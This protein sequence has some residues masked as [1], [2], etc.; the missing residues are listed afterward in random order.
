[1]QPGLQLGR[2]NFLEEVDQITFV[3]VEGQQF[4]HCILKLFTQR[5]D[6]FQIRVPILHLKPADN[7]LVLLVLCC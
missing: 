5:I 3:W 1:M 7:N 4:S 6:H 2:K